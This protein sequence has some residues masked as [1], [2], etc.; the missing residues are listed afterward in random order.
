MKIIFRA[1]GDTTTGLGH[2]MRSAAL[3]Q[4]LQPHFTCSFHTRNPEYFPV[5]EFAEVPEIKKIMTVDMLEDARELA[6]DSTGDSII[7]L[8]GYQFI[9][10][11]QQVIKNA[12]RKLVC[13][14]DIISY[15]F[16]S[17]AVINHAG[18]ID[19]SA[20][21]KES[22]TQMLLG[23][24]YALI[25]PLFCEMPRPPRNINDRKL[26]IALGGAD[27][28]ND[29]EKILEQLS[30]T[31]YFEE[32]HVIMGAANPYFEK[33]KGVFNNKGIQFYRSLSAH[34]VRD[35]IY[36]CTYAVLP[37]STISYE[38]MSVGGMVFLYQIA[39]NQKYIYRFFLENGLA[40]PFE[41][42]GKTEALEFHSSL[43]QQEKYF[44]RKS[45]D[46]LAGFFSSL[47]ANHSN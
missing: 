37:P 24:A 39:D 29:T 23:P 2:I 10:P 28:N 46:R 5:S 26:L 31:S 1:D 21:S 19:A 30:P 8:D 14:D 13:I 7:I 27:L 6:E 45:A 9:T 16:V 35:L 38:Y 15:H 22:Y 42:I 20:Y 25:K 40:F 41:R 33:V 18:G 44:D 47:A 3:M 4:M 43:Q 32:I 11:Y 34:A 36:N 17:D 12:G